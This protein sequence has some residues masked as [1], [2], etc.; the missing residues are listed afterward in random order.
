MIFIVVI[1]LAALL[2]PVLL[3]V[4]LA[5]RGG[6]RTVLWAVLLV[7]AVALTL[8][9]L[10]LAMLY[11]QAP[12]WAWVLVG[13]CALGV[14]VLFVLLGRSVGWR[15]LPVA[16]AA[17]LIPFAL[18]L[19]VVVLMVVPLAPTAVLEARAGQIAAANGFTALLPQGQAMEASYQPVNALPAP[20]AGLSIEYADFDLQERATDGPLTAQDLR[21]LVAPGAAPVS[22]GPII[23]GD[24]VLTDRTVRGSPAVAAELVDVPPE[25]LGKADEGEP[26]TMLVLGM[27]GVEVLLRSTGFADCSTE[28]CTD[29]P[30]LTV[31]ELVAVAETLRP[32]G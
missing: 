18:A 9:A 30:P 25:S 28:P 5:R 21:A 6:P 32:V 24:V 1:A 19:G 7:V 20:D 31:D 13:G 29:V 22:G 15:P 4:L 16:A 27:D 26:T 11:Y 17:A 3:V 2:A 12:V 14:V 23:P 8:G 10:S